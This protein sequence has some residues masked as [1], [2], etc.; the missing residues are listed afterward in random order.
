MRILSLLLIVL[1][2]LAY[3]N[4][5]NYTLFKTFKNPDKFSRL[6][7]D[8]DEYKLILYGPTSKQPTSYR[9]FD[10]KLMDSSRWN[11][12]T[13][14]PSYIDYFSR[15]EMQKIIY[16]TETGEIAGQGFNISNPDIGYMN[17]YYSVPANSTK[18]VSV[19]QVIACTQQ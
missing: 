16:G 3:A 13:F 5:L 7:F 9:Y 8:T 2:L 4:T 19:K 6:F 10:W 11:P 1:T 15:G 17:F 12:F 18:S 14:K